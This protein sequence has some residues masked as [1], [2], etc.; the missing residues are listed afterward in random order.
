MAHRRFTPGALGLPMAV[1][2]FGQPIERAFRGRPSAQQVKK[3][4][5]FFGWH[6]RHHPGSMRRRQRGPSAL[7]EAR[8]QFQR[9]ECR[10]ALRVPVQAPRD[11][12]R[13]YRTALGRGTPQ[14]TLAPLPVDLDHGDIKVAAGQVLAQGF[15]LGGDKEPMQLLFNSLEILHGFVRFATLTQP[16]LELVHGVGIAGQEGTVLHCLPRDS[17]LA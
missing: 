14:D 4:F 10:T 9:T 11:P 6:M 16:I 8:A 7:D 15:A 12:H 13:S 5:A 1:Q 17:P 2:G 3:F